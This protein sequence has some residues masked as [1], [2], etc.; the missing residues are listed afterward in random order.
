VHVRW[1]E[2]VGFRNYA[3]LSFAPDSG[4]NAL[5]GRNGQGKT[6][7]LE[8]I[9]LLLTGRSFRTPRLAECVA[10]DASEAA[11]AGETAD[12]DRTR[13]IVEILRKAAGE[14]EALA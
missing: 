2:L 11:L 4:L 14:I 5:V 10:W 1:L 3:S 13:G 12:G 6:S 8:A 9:H 7:L